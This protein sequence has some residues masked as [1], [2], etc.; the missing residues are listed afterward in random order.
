MPPTAEARGH[1][2]ANSNRLATIPPLLLLCACDNEKGCTIR[3]AAKDLMWCSCSGYKRICHDLEL[4]CGMVRY[5][6]PRRTPHHREVK[7]KDPTITHKQ[8]QE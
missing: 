2:V 6:K 1:L 3:F 7:Q 8:R 5:T 4:R